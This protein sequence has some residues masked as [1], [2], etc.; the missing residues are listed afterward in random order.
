MK[1][2]I[3]GLKEVLR[4]L[5]ILLPVME[6]SLGSREINKYTVAVSSHFVM[7]LSTP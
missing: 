7:A 6:F 5:S 2:Q 3:A 4:A 1:M